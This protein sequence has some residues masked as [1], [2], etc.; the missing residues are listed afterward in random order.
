MSTVAAAAEQETQEQIE[1]RLRQEA[2]A[3]GDVFDPADGI[4]VDS[5][6]KPPA[7]RVEAESD[8]D[9]ETLAAIAGDDKPRMI[10]HSRFNEV[11]EE[12][13]LHRARVLEL[14]EEL[15]R[16]K[17]SGSAAQKP[18]TEE[19]PPAEFDFDA[20]E[21]SYS[22]AILDG[23]QT[24]AKNIRAEIRKQEQQAA[25]ARAEA[26]ADRR[27]AANRQKDDQERAG[28]EFKLELAKAYAV[29]PFLDADSADKNQDAIE[30]T[31]VWVQHFTGKG[32]S[33]AKALASAVQKV[34]PRYAK[35]EPV[36]DAT[37]KP[38]LAQGLARSQKI[39]AKP[40]GVGERAASIDVS[41]MS[42][43]DIKN[44]SPEDEAR[45]AGNFV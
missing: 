38:D 41:K 5:G 26:A 17:G 18:A 16:V 33:P 22:T 21:E 28:L 45:L 11:N 30:E 15:A 25:D 34:A 13:K 19:K 4:D 24:K 27:Y 23:D 2:I 3:A 43:K 35:V 42:T 44:L 8:I 7:A 40:A 9:P 12:S 36:Q 29:H 1:E 31:L 10:P 37:P 6:A 32:E 39:P 14:E 20:A